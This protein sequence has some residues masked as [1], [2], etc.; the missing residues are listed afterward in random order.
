MSCDSPDKVNCPEAKGPDHDFGQPPILVSLGGGKRALVIGQKS[1]M[2]HA[3][4]P[5]Q[6]GEVLWQK[7][8]AKGG[9]LGGIQWGSASD[10]EK[11]YVAIGDL[12]FKGLAPG[13]G[14][15]LNPNQGGGLAALKLANG[16]TAWLAK[17]PVCGDRPRCSPAQSAAVSAIPGVVFS[18]SLDGRIRAYAT[19]DGSVLWEY[20]TVR[21]FETVNGVKARGGSIDAHGPVIA[22]GY[23]YTNSG[24]GTWGGIPGNVLLAFSAG[25]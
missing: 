23:L 14:L 3:I 25:Q 1:G 24:F 16:E 18:G 6:R 17:P 8:V 4:D 19:A 22:G 9:A 10:G 7:R 13:G 5:D 20:D 12:A 21:D 2:V 11:M 15:L